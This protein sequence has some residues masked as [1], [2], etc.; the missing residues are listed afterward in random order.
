[1]RCSAEDAFRFE[2]NALKFR[3]TD[4]ITM[5]HAQ[6]PESL[7]TAHQK[8]RMET[9]IDKRHPHGMTGIDHPENP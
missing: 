3:S 2:G 8:Q 5:Q 4:P 9:I 6:H 7:I 1:L